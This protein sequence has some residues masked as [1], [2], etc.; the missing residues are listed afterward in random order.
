MNAIVIM[1]KAPFPNKVKTRLMP[2][3]EPE[4]ASDLYH[5][6]LLDKIEQVRS[7]SDVHPFIAYTPGTA[8]AFFR[9]ILPPGFELI[10]QSG[11]GL[12]ERLADISK[13]LFRQGF[14]KVVLLDSD[15]PNLPPGFIK[16]AILRL[17]E[18]DV[19]LGTCE[20]GGYYLM[21]LRS[22][23]PVLFKGIP[24]STSQVAELTIGKAQSL[25]LKI[26]LLDTW[27]DVDTFEELLRLKR[28]LDSSPENQ[29]NLF[30]CNNTCRAISRMNIERYA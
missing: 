2:P 11:A 30:F 6:F 13:Y 25:G 27:Y 24:W 8:E 17:D 16:D 26:S 15:T 9:S 19:V 5:N 10:S 28:E 12:G 21:G 22:Y 20:D 23:Q 4:E 14:R 1:A 29:K 18:V 7:I 3:L